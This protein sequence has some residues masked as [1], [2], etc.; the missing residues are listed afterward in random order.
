VRPCVPVPPGA[1][2]YDA[3]HVRRSFVQFSPPRVYNSHS[4][5]GARTIWGLV[6]CEG[7]ATS[8]SLNGPSGDDD[9]AWMMSESLSHVPIPH[10]PGYRSEAWALWLRPEA[11]A[12]VKR[13][14]VPFSS[15][16]AFPPQEVSDSFM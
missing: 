16:S 1:L 10:G 8:A 14:K 11:M 4:P 5:S 2:S 12:E 7:S 3:L 6:C 13:W 9:T 15:G